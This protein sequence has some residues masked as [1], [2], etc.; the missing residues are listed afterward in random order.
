MM[1]LKIK[2]LMLAATQTML[3]PLIVNHEMLSRCAEAAPYLEFGVGAP[4]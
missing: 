3:L 1:A 4:W 2:S